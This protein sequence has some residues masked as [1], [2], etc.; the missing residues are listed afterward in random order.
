MENPFYNREI[1]ELNDSDNET[2]IKSK[3][4]LEDFLTNEELDIARNTIN[5]ISSSATASPLQHQHL[6][7]DLPL[8]YNECLGRLLEVFPDISHDHAKSLYEARRAPNADLQYDLGR[9]LAQG[10]I[11]QVLDSGDYPKERERLNELKRKRST[12]TTSDDERVAKWRNTKRE[13]TSPR[14]YADQA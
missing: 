2:E 13:G 8:S 1:V 14:I 7:P 3:V 10:L 6:P 12:V 9:D 11:M 5:E 4:I